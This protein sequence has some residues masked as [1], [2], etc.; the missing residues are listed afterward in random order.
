MKK[1]STQTLE[2]SIVKKSKSDSQ[3]SS[4]RLNNI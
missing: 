2:E 3:V 1:S 4:D